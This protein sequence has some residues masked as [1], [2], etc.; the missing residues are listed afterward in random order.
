MVSAIFE[1]LISN[2]RSII[3]PSDQLSRLCEPFW[4]WKP[5]IVLLVPYLLS[6]FVFALTNWSHLWADLRCSY[7]RR[8]ES[9]YQGNMVSRSLRYIQ[10]VQ[11]WVWN[12]RRASKIQ[13]ATWPFGSSNIL[14]V[15]QSITLREGSGPDVHLFWGMPVSS[16]TFKLWDIAKHPWFLC[17]N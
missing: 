6:T 12:C 1:S 3:L 11:K 17:E 2:L 5:W 9:Q 7:K 16:S 10:K 15:Y 14:E 4:C 13:G 8:G